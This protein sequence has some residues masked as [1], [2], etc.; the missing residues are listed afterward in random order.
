MMKHINIYILEKLKLNKDIKSEE[1]SNNTFIDSIVELCGINKDDDVLYN[2]IRDALYE[3]GINEKNIEIYCNSKF[4]LSNKYKD[5]NIN[6]KNNEYVSKIIFDVVGVF[7]SSKINDIIFKKYPFSIFSCK[8][9]FV[10]SYQKYGD[11]YKIYIANNEK[12][13]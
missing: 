9:G 1:S 8:N 2:G 12:V 4:D 3:Y 5:N 13:K 10:V 6:F 7:I 11:K